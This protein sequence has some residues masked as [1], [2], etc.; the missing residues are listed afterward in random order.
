MDTRDTISI[1]IIT[2]FAIARRMRRQRGALTAGPRED[3][4]HPTVPIRFL[5]TRSAAVCT[6]SLADT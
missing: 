2:V 6:I 3:R 5:F 1:F 4:I